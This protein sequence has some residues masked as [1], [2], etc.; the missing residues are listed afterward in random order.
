[1]ISTHAKKKVQSE[2][3]NEA[4]EDQQPNADDN[5]SI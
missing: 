3:G 4:F 1:M 5:L 2:P